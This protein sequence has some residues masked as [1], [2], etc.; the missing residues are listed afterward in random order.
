M[1][2]AADRLA[3]DVIEAV[4]L[5]HSASPW[6]PERRARW[7]ELTGASEA[8]TRSLCDYARAVRLILEEQGRGA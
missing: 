6:T 1:A 2:D 7:K 3:Q 5:F 8:T 4:L